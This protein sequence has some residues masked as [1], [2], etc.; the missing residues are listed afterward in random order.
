MGKEKQKI[1]VVV[2][3]GV[4]VFA[5]I[6][7]L[8]IYKTYQTIGVTRGALADVQSKIDAHKEKGR[9]IPTLKEKK[10]QIELVV[11]DFAKILPDDATAEHYQLLELV[12][13]FKEETN[14]KLLRFDPAKKKKKKKKGEGEDSAF[15]RHQFKLEMEGRFFDIA[16]LMNLIERT[17]KFLKIDSFHCYRP[18][19]GNREPGD[20]THLVAEVTMSTFT[21]KRPKSDK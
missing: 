9:A 17:E 11:E 3:V 14:I 18:G 5:V 1:V 4:V 6:V 19:K 13:D 16:R 15:L 2:A 20:L 21:Y 10:R 8:G 7:Y 12:D